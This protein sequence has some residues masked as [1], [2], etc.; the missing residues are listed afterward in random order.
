[1]NV[2]YGAQ[3]DVG[4]AREQNEDCY[5][6]GEGARAAQHG[7]LLIVCDGMGGHASGEVASRMAVDSILASYYDDPS[8]DRPAALEHAFQQANAQ[9]HAQGHG[10]MGTTGVAALLL[11]DTLS[12][13]NV[14]DSR[15]YLIRDGAVQQISHDHSLVA[16]QVAA[17]LI[18]PEQARR[19]TIKN[20]ITRALGHQPEVLVDL[21]E[22]DLRPGDMVLLCSDGLHGLVDDDELLQAAQMDDLD[23]V[24]QQLVE[25]A[26]RRGGH[27]NITVVLAQVGPLSEP[28]SAAATSQTDL[29]AERA[30]ERL[31]DHAPAPPA[32][33]ITERLPEDQPAPVTAAPAVPAAPVERPLN[34]RG[35]LLSALLLTLLV[36]VILIAQFRPELLPFLE[37]PPAA[38]SVAA[39]ATPATP[40]RLPTVT[41]APTD[42]PQPTP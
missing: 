21:F 9:I 36:G 24:C 38:T 5:G 7:L 40:T 1:M 14:G 30:T 37:R 17:G 33:R 26:N 10:S 3:T 41:S 12:V 19:S 13:A 18:T 8:E 2:R 42:V 16:D 39:T 27:D 25:L 11:G 29:I 35:A 6:I 32:E 4:R 22:T 23:L 31:P 15:A 34:K 20:V 28:A